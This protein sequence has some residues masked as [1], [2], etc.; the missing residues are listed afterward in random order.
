LSEFGVDNLAGSDRPIGVAA[1]TFA[2]F[3]Q[4]ARAHYADGRVREAFLYFV[5][6]A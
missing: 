4:D 1:Q 6:G 5:A 3:M 2:G